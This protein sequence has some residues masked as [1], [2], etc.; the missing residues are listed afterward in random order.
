VHRGIKN[1]EELTKNFK[2]TFSFKNNNSLIK[3]TLQGIKNN[4]FMTEGSMYDT[5]IVT[6]PVEE[7]LHCYNV[8]EENQED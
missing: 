1:W 8:E 6:E 2:V 7:I 3:S 4:I 5:P